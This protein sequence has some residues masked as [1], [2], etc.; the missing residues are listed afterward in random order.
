MCISE[1]ISHGHEYIISSTR[2]NVLRDLTLITVNVRRVV[3]TGSFVISY[4]NR[5]YEIIAS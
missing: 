2:D 1:L 3:G 4:S 5:S